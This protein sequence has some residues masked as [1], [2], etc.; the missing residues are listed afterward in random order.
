MKDEVLREMLGFYSLT[1]YHS[2]MGEIPSLW[3]KINDL[4]KQIRNLENEIKRMQGK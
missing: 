3:K 2:Y 1:E 4:E